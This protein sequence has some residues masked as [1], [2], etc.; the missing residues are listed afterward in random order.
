M[1]GQWRQ[2]YNTVRPHATLGYRPPAPGAY[3]AC[4]ETR[5]SGLEIKRD[6]DPLQ[7]S[8]VS[9]FAKSPVRE[10][11]ELAFLI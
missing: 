4:V 3:R 1:I 9:I 10:S 11:A 8:G 5:F 2:Q 6:H 7:S